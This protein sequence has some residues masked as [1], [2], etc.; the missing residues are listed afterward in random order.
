MV[1]TAVVCF[2][3]GHGVMRKVDIT[4]VAW[5]MGFRDWDWVAREELGSWEA[6]RRVHSS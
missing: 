3:D 4:V 5:V 6:Y 2:S 1:S